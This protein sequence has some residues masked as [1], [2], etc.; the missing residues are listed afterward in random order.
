MYFVFVLHRDA[1]VRAL[2]AYLL[3]RRSTPMMNYQE[4]SIP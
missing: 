4:T 3:G 1:L 2:W